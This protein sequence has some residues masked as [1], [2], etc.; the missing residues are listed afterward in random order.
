MSIWKAI[1]K[2]HSFVNALDEILDLV[3]SRRQNVETISPAEI[4]TILKKY[5][6][7][8]GGS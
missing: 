6:L 1:L 5:G 3:E 7:Y 2:I 8:P 4:I